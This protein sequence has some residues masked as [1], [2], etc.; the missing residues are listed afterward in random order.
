MTQGVSRRTLNAGAWVFL[1]AFH[2]GYMSDI[3]WH[4]NSFLSQYFGSTLS[5]LGCKRRLVIF[6]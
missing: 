2:E 5:V 1:K 4:C 6:I 3:M